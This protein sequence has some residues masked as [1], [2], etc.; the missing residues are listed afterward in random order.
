MRF[1]RAHEAK[2]I[3]V[4]RQKQFFVTPTGDIAN[5]GAP[6]LLGPNGMA[7]VLPDVEAYRDARCHPFELKTKSI[8]TRTHKTQELEHGFSLRLYREYVKYQKVTGRKLIIVVNELKTGE[9]LARTLDALGEPRLDA[10]GEPRISEGSAMG[11]MVF[12]PRKLFRVFHQG[13]APD[14]PLFADVPLQPT[15]PTFEPSDEDA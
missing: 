3:L 6:K 12:I 5:G 8:P 2:L 15:L 1:G 11:D 9:L 7:I 14:V 10:Y 13:R 4:L